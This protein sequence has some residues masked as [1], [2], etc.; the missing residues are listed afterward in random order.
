M[1]RF[2]L[3]HVLLYSVVMAL[4]THGRYGRIGEIGEEEREREGE[5]DESSFNQEKRKEEGGR[6]MITLSESGK[7]HKSTYS[8]LLM[9]NVTRIYSKCHI[10]LCVY[11]FFNH[12]FF[13]ICS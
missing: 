3:H 13:Q 4:R 5:F 1:K 12:C 10:F 9:Y 6:D 11:Y 2:L 8:E 7:T